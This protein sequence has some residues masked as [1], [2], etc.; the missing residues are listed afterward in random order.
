MV[1]PLPGG[2]GS[3]HVLVSTGLII[4]YGL[5]QDKAIAFT[6]IFHAWQT[7]VIILV[8]ALSLL[9]SQLIKNKIERNQKQNI[10]S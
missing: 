10:I 6:F 1:V 8:G 4:L 3:F 7:L 2:A 5:A 9:A